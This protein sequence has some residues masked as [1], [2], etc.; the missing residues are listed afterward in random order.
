MSATLSALADSV[1]DYLS[2]QPNLWNHE[3]IRPIL[4]DGLQWFMQQHTP[5]PGKEKT[6][7]VQFKA[8]RAQAAD[9]YVALTFHTHGPEVAGLLTAIL[10]ADL[11][12]RGKLTLSKG[13]VS[14]ILNHP[15]ALRQYG[16]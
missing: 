15:E 11:Q 6:G 14:L 10:L 1:R 8:A 2:K 4:E 7:V 13:K 9:P 5:V 16:F 3:V 12:D